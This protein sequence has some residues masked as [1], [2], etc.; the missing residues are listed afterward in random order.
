MILLDSNLIIYS[1]DPAQVTVRRFIGANQI[2]ASAISYVETL[3]FHQ[4]STQQ[5][6]SLERFFSMIPVLPLEHDVLEEAVR[7]RQQRRMSLGDA[8]IAGTALVHN[9]PLATNN[10]RDFKYI[11][12]LAVTIPV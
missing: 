9:L 12:G 8:L 2:A 7:L 6:A 4:I 1:T 5:R 11:A 10:A 3:G